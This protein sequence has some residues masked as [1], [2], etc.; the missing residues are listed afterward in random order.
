VAV[1]EINKLVAFAPA[2]VA[3]D[4]DILDLFFG[5]FTVSPV[6]LGKGVSSIDKEYPVILFGPVEKPQGGRQGAV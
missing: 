2:Q 3:D 6:D 4:G 5:K 1:D